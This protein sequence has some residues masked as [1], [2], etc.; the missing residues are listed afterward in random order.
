MVN[1]FIVVAVIAWSCQILLSG[2]QIHRFNQSFAALCKKG[3]VGVGRYGGR[4][5]P[6][7]IVAIAV[8]EHQRVTGSLLMK[9]IT[10]FA[11]PAEIPNIIG[12][13][14]DELQPYMIFPSDLR[15]QNALLLATKPIT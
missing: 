6:R 14:P 1:A 15:C 3:K 12:L 8:N 4:F 2:W 9:G 7:V 10:I 13:R 5:K 11:R